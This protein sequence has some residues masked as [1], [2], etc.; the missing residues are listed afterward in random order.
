M[1]EGPGVDVLGKDGKAPAL[2]RWVHHKA[3]ERLADEH[4]TLGVCLCLDKCGDLARQLRVEW[5]HGR[6]VIW[7]DQKRVE[8]GSR[9]DAVDLICFVLHLACGTLCELLEGKR[10]GITIRRRAEG[11]AD[12]AFKSLKQIH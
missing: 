12:A 9:V 4:V 5:P 8:R 7:G 2:E 11:V 10:S 1:T 3:G 6:V